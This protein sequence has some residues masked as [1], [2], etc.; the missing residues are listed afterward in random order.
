[1]HS[2]GIR[3][4][5]DTALRLVSHGCPESS[6]LRLQ[7]IEILQPLQSIFVDFVI[8][9]LQFHTKV[10]IFDFRCHTKATV[11]T[12]INN[13]NSVLLGYTEGTFAREN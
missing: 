11:L 2:K 7:N 3:K 5:T 1:M 13:A 10:L 4:A 12:I 8:F 6:P 9:T